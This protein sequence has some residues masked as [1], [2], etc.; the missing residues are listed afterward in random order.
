MT[1]E[2]ERQLKRHIEE[3]R[4]AKSQA[5]VAIESRELIEYVKELCAKSRAGKR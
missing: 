2:E 1:A 5:E 4:Q 3:L